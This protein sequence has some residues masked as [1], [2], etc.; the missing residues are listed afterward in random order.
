VKF[1]P[2]NS[3]D[4]KSSKTNFSKNDVLYGK[5]RPYLN[6]VL[7]PTFD[8]VCST[9]ILVLKPKSNISREFLAYFLRSYYVLSKMTKLMYGTKM[10]R[11]KIQ[12]LQDVKIELP[13]K[14]ERQQIVSK[15]EDSEKLVDRVKQSVNKITEQQEEL[16]KNLQNLQNS[17][18]DKAFLG[19]LMN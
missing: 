5:L 8:G 6:K 9:D 4:I 11:A 15:L 12:D 16:T 2:T 7:L 18:L 14:K 3:L 13:S 17:I 19:E 10:P 1:T